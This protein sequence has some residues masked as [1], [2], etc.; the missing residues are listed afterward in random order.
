MKKGNRK[1]RKDFLFDDLVTLHSDE[2][3]KLH[4]ELKEKLSRKEK[5]HDKFQ[6][7]RK[8][9]VE[10]VRRVRG[11]LMAPRNPEIRDL[12]AKL[13]IA[14]KNRDSSGKL[15]AE[16]DSRVPPSPND[17]IKSLKDRHKPLWTISNRIQ[18]IPNLKEEI[19]LFES[20]FEYQA[21]YEIAVKSDEQ[22][23]I[24]RQSLKDIK[25]IMKEIKKFELD[26]VNSNHFTE[27]QNKY[28]NEKIGWKSV[29][30]SSKRISEIEDWSQ[31][32]REEKRRVHKEIQRL[33]AYLRIKGKRA[34]L[35]SLKLK[36]EEIREKAETGATLSLDDLS[37]LISTGDI[38]KITEKKNE[39]VRK[40]KKKS[41]KRRS[42]P[43]RGGART[44][45]RTRNENEND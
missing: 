43:I 22:E 17:I 14:K 19:D 8:D 1:G 45:K 23:Q 7:E 40:D 10:Y 11:V 30:K 26:D 15:R 25:T 28:P 29:D 37:A 16:L 12:V 3:K 27:L 21:M 9:L 6:L 38:G 31:S 20:Y 32:W 2:I 35:E 13:K 36:S 33:E 44:K 24:W 42:A 41:K 4:S 34:K 39:S 18:E 5:E